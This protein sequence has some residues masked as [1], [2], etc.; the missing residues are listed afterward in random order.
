MALML[1]AAGWAADLGRGAPALHVATVDHGLRAESSAEAA[2]VAAMAAGLGLPHATLPWLG[3]KPRTRIQESARAARYALLAEHARVLGADHVLVGHHADDQAE[4]VLM[5]FGRGS[6]IAG[7]AGMRRETPLGDGVTLVRPLLDVPKADLVTLCR[8]AG[9]AVIDDPSN[10]DPAYARARLRADAPLLSRLGL[11]RTTLRKLAR[12]AARADAALEA[13]TDRVDA[14]IGSYSEAYG[15]SL[16]AH[17]DIEPEILLRLLRRAVAH[18]APAPGLLRL[19]RLERLTDALLAAIREARP[20]RATLGGA[21][22]ILD[23]DAVLTVTPAPPR[24][25][26]QVGVAART[27]AGLD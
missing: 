8:D 2:Q 4:T 12:R 23:A 17:R 16:A 13:E 18:V 15:A 24:Q 5:R 9:L 22:V 3:P 6:G 21:R 25:R 10:R 26:G 1:L 20:C 27:R 14:L 11:G 19:E 7:L